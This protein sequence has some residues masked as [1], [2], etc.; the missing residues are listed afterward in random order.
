[1]SRISDYGT[2]ID[3]VV[4]A[5]VLDSQGEILDVKGADI[6][7]LEA[8]KG[9]WNSDHRNAFPDVVG[10]IVHAR[11]IF[12]PEDCEDDRQKYF[13]N[14]FK[15]P[16]I[17]AKGY[18]FD[19]D[20][21][22]RAAQAVSAILRNQSRT[23]SPLKMKASVEGG[24][25]ERGKTNTNILKRT[26]IT[27][28]ALTLTPANHSTLIETSELA[29][30]SRPGDA[31]LIS[32]YV[33][34]AKD[35]VPAFVENPADR[36]AYK[37][38]KIAS[39]TK[40]LVSGL[41]KN[42]TNDEALE[43]VSKQ[44]LL[45]QL[46][47]DPNAKEVAAWLSEKVSRDDAQNWFLRAYKQDPS[48]FN[49]KNKE[50][51]Q[52]Y[53]GMAGIHPK[54]ELGSF[55]FDK[56]HSFED[57]LKALKDAEDKLHAQSD[58]KYVVPDD[59]TKKLIDL[60]NGTA[61][62]DLGKGYDPAE[63]RAATHCGNI[64]AENAQPGDRNYDDRLLS[65]RKEKKIGDKTYHEPLLTFVEN[66]GYIGE[67]KGRNNQK[68]NPKYHDAIIKLL[69]HPRIK[70]NIGGGA[71][72]NKN[73]YLNDLSEDKR[74]ALLAKKP[75]LERLFNS[76]TGHIE[77]VDSYP[78]KHQK[79]VQQHNA[80][81]DGISSGNYNEFSTLFRDADSKKAKDLLSK[82]IASNS[83]KDGTYYR[84]SE[85]TPYDEMCAVIA[86][87]PHLDSSHIDKALSDYVAANT[88]NGIGYL[89]SS[90]AA[91]KSHITTAL[92]SPD[93]R[94]RATAVQ[95]PHFKPEHM[96]TALADPHADVRCAA[97]RSPHFKP[98]HMDTVL[99]DPHENVRRVAV[100]SEHFKPEHMDT[101]LASPDERVRAAA[102]QS[103]H[104]KPE[105]MDTALA[106]PSERVRAAA[107]ESEHFKPEHMDTALAD[108]SEDVQIALLHRQ[109][110]FK[111]MK[112]SLTA[113][114]GSAGSPSSR[115]GG[116]VLQTETIDS[117]NKFKHISC[118]S[119]GKEQP[120]LKYQVKC[121]DCHKNFPFDTLAKF[122]LA[123]SQELKVSLKK[124]DDEDEHAKLANLM[125]TDGKIASLYR[126]MK[127]HPSD[128]RMHEKAQ[129]K[130]KERI[131]EL[132]SNP[133]SHIDP[134][135]P[136]QAPKSAAATPAAATPAAVA[137]APAAPERAP[138]VPTGKRL[139]PEQTESPVVP[140]R[141]LV[142]T[143]DERRG[144]YKAQPLS[145]KQK[146]YQEALREQMASLTNTPPSEENGTHSFTTHKLI[147]TPTV[148]RRDGTTSYGPSYSQH[149]IMYNDRPVGHAE[150]HHTKG[151]SPYIKM[152]FDQETMNRLPGD[153][154]LIKLQ[155]EAA[156][157]QYLASSH[158]KRHLK[159]YKEDVSARA[160]RL[161]IDR[162][163]AQKGRSQ[164][165]IMNDR[166]ERNPNDVDNKN[167]APKG[168]IPVFDRDRAVSE[169][170]QP[171]DPK[172]VART[173]ANRGVKPPVR[174]SSMETPPTNTPANTKWRSVPK[175]KK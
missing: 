162:A 54:S 55:R 25:I 74:K 136:K 152:D 31:A 126:I 172:E 90:H 158:F 10:R 132:V 88:A 156:L 24:I 70:E 32:E 60:G 118:P 63:G 13:W 77:D 41:K 16:I 113:G 38:E 137:T 169:P 95:S 122:F 115:V 135:A 147:A 166:L 103:E 138:V 140:G 155:S 19:K 84:D 64:N 44:Q 85:H 72:P 145:P 62:Y 73:F 59:K 61:W 71:L 53:M 30:S 160:D 129:Q 2:P 43:K 128:W 17:Y 105:H 80:G 92:A 9:V 124:A 104:F 99:A 161:N 165:D 149:V 159:D 168:E 108:P 49:D 114:F 26:K 148:S 8:G 87:S 121:R 75:S 56:S 1:M 146:E 117:G 86:N 15:S 163:N 18:L 109:E 151:Q 28:V 29:K 35:S 33:H 42:T 93:E 119:C 141:H 45:Q 78:A 139:L 101:A 20:G 142:G 52:H 39:L 120:Y 46:G 171:V 91:N 79:E 14:Q 116:S 164:T 65:L 150:V 173:M 123:K 174:V 125:R 7:E 58:E 34:F 175:G 5:Q 111:N 157:K 50:A 69:E 94:V 3:G 76:K 110:E 40:A 27:K 143:E 96:D 6:S 83:A 133:A 144:K 4:A 47:A 23:D 81:I 112:K 68:P 36:I 106:D 89:L 102:V 131:A 51:I 82:L 66:N 100:Q 21:E 48:V 154:N 130:I 12:G 37:V 11:K 107:V 134:N 153:K 22:H 170:Q 127:D 167:A 97:L 98:E 67:S 57:G